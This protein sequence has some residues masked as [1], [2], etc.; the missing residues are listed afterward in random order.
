MHVRAHYWQ[1]C[2]PGGVHRAG[3]CCPW[4]GALAYILWENQAS[5][6]LEEFVQQ[7]VERNSLLVYKHTRIRQTH[8]SETKGSRQP[9]FPGDHIWGRRRQLITI[10]RPSKRP[11]RQISLGSYVFQEKGI[12]SNHFYFLGLVSFGFRCRH[13]ICCTKCI[14][15][16]IRHTELKDQWQATPSSL[17]LESHSEIT[18]SHSWPLFPRQ[19]FPR[20]WIF[21]IALSL[22]T[23][24]IE[25]KYKLN[26]TPSNKLPTAI[27]KR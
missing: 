14:V 9:Q 19:K 5:H 10:C 3:V 7:S 4:W 15:S 13:P 27:P 6:L 2:F 23:N 17:W 20:P 1:T 26:A 22:S 16:Y 11:L 18:P 8:P 25:T 24:W 12:W 21:E